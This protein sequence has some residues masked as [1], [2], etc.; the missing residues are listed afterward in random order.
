[1]DTADYSEEPETTAYFPRGLPDGNPAMPVASSRWPSDAQ[2]LHALGEWEP[3]ALLL[4]HVAGCYVGVRDDRHILTVAGS[5]A[6]KGV[7]LIVPNLL[8]WPGSALAIDPKGELASLTASRRSSE[9]SAHVQGM[10]G[11]VVALDPFNRVCGPAA[12]FR[13]GFNPLVDLDP[14]TDE[15]HDLASLIADSLVI[16]QEG[17]AAHWTQSARA[18]LRGLVLYVAKTGAPLE[19]HLIRVRELI[20]QSPDDFSAMLGMMGSMAGPI[21]RAAHSLQLKPA[22]ERGSVISTCDVQ[23]DFLEG[24]PMGRVLAGHDFALEDL[25]KERVTVYLCLPAGRLATHG[26]WLRLMVNLALEA[27]EQT[28]PLPEDKPPVLFCLDE[29]AALGHMENIERAAGQIAGFGVKLWP[30]VQDVTQLQRDYKASWETFMGNAGVLTFFGNTDLTTLEH[31][32][33]RLGECELIRT[34]QGFSDNL[35]EQESHS[36]ALRRDAIMG[37]GSRSVSSGT[38]RQRGTSESE[39]ILRNP[40]MTLDEVARH[41]ARERG[42][43]LAFLPKLGP[44]ALNRCFYYAREDAGLFGNLYDPV[45]GRGA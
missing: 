17:A 22:G 19:R 9:G 35:T 18:F 26:R 34:T 37:K 41:F 3:G 20:T 13:G 4:G 45:P 15:G 16:Q 5:R 10:G 30:I 32:S 27:M 40:L 12:V 33:K 31:I 25:K 39:T 14:E 43:L 1:M 11:R 36:G 23:T 29:F 8:Y 6:G 24:A 38:T 2:V 42:N 21:A 7:S 28:G 44:V